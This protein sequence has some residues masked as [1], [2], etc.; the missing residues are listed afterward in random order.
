MYYFKNNLS[1]NFYNIVNITITILYLIAVTGIVIVDS[2][3]ITLLDNIIKFC[4]SIFLII[5]FNPITSEDIN[6]FDKKI[7]FTAGMFLFLSS[8]ITIFIKNYFTPLTFK[9]PIKL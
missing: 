7:V 4:V 2:N 6:K 3:Y 8:S 5:K 9:T 1:K